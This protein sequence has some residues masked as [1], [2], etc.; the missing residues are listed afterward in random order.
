AQGQL[1]LAQSGRDAGEG[2]REEEIDLSGRRCQA[3]PEPLAGGQGVLVLD[4][5]DGQAALE[6]GAHV[7]PVRIGVLLEQLAVHVG[8]LA[9]EPVADALV[10]WK[11]DVS[12]PRNEL[13]RGF[14]ARPDVV[15][16]ANSCRF[17][18]PTST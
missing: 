2:R 7:V 17:V 6:L 16:Y 13:C 8:D 12:P 4:V 11:L 9:P 3:L 14:H 15:P 5:G 18:L 1:V 10:G